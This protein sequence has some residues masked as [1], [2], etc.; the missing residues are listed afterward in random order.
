MSPPSTL[1]HYLVTSWVPQPKCKQMRHLM[2]ISQSAALIMGKIILLSWVAC[3]G[4]LTHTFSNQQSYKWRKNKSLAPNS[5]PDI[6]LPIMPY[7]A[8]MGR[9]GPL[10]YAFQITKWQKTTHK[11]WQTCEV[12]QVWSTVP[13]E[14]SS[15]C[16]VVGWSPGDEQLP[17]HAHSP[18]TSAPRYTSGYDYAREVPSGSSM[19]LLGCTANMQLWWVSQ[20]YSTIL[21]SHSTLLA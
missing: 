10:V 7:T 2:K 21:I 18:W 5:A 17:H 15:P 20:M 12:T 6:C 13:E 8:D 4:N 19:L 9:L 16:W 14:C 3:N 1:W 11:I